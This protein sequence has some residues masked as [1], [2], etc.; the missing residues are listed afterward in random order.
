[1]KKI[2]F[3]CLVLT[4]FWISSLAQVSHD[5]NPN[6]MTPAVTAKL[7]TDQ[8]PALILQSFKVQFNPKN[9]ATW[10][11]FPYALK[12]YGWVYDVGS[13]NVDLDRFEVKMKTDEGADFWAVYT[14]NGELIETREMSTDIAIPPDVMDKFSKSQYKDWKIIG[15][16]EIIRF[17]HDHELNKSH[18]EQHFR[19]TVEKNNVKRGISFNWSGDKK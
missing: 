11:R 8:I 19:I 14:K 5:Y 18:V 6:D 7:T 12:E 3:F 4:T 15:N 9:P 17:Y 16:K 1:M 13:E 2:L 10:S